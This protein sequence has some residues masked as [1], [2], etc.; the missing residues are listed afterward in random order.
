MLKQTL[1]LVAALTLLAAWQAAMADE[2]TVI[3]PLEA[4][5]CDLPNAPPRIKPDA[6]YDAL[7]EAKQRVNDF[8]A[9]MVLYRGCL[10]QAGR[11]EAVTEGNRVALAQAHNYSVEMEERI[12]EQ[13]NIAV[14]AY[15]AR[16][17]EAGQN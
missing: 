12:A 15:K 9:A 5:T 14:R 8:Q 3:L 13:F 17:A 7:V 11:T 6:D 2:S 10:D 1:V 16:Q 4:Q